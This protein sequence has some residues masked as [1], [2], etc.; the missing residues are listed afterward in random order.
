MAPKKKKKIVVNKIPLNYKIDDFPKKFNNIPQLYLELLENKLKVKP[1]LKNQDYIPK[2]EDIKN[3]KTDNLNLDQ[4]TLRQKANERDYNYEK[5][6]RTK[7]KIE[8]IKE[9]E[10][11][12]NDKKQ[13]TKS[14]ERTKRSKHKER[15][16]SKER[17]K[18][19]TKSKK[20]TKN[21][22]RSKSKE[23]SKR[24]KKRS[25]SKERSKRDKK[26]TKSKRDKKTK[27]KRNENSKK[28]EEILKDTPNKQKNAPKL[29]DIE[30]KFENQG[31]IKDVSRITRTDQ[32][33]LQE[34][35]E[36]LFKFELLKRSYT[37]YK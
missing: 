15:T 1:E 27:S 13:R 37:D 18:K 16:K 29:S 5:V 2:I 9:N 33:E 10:R 8:R 23:R 34:K 6:E 28:L 19:R 36:Y 20:R 25:K 32:D 31:G 24:D 21:K 30:H 14:K 3:I 4:S 26:R 22:K 17:T 35:R 11:S 12:K 7:D